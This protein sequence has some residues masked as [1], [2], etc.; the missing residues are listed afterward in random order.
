MFKYTATTAF[1]VGCILLLASIPMVI[2]SAGLGGST[3]S[4]KEAAIGFCTTRTV[5]TP[6]VHRFIANC[7]Y[8]AGKQSV[9]DELHTRCGRLIDSTPVLDDL[10]IFS[11]SDW[12]KMLGTSSIVG[13][14][15]FLVGY[16]IVDRWWRTALAIDVT[17]DDSH[18][19]KMT[20]DQKKMFTRVRNGSSGPSSRLAAANANSDALIHVTPGQYEEAIEVQVN[21]RTSCLLNLD[22]L[23]AVVSAIAVVILGIVLHNIKYEITGLQKY[24][25]F[26]LQNVSNFV[27][28][29]FVGRDEITGGWVQE[30]LTVLSDQVIKYLSV[31]LTALGIS[32]F[33]VAFWLMP[34]LLR[35]IISR[36][37]RA[38]RAQIPTDA[39]QQKQAPA[40]RR[41][42]SP[43][44]SAPGGM[45]DDDQ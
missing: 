26:P 1:V 4:P 34:G 17:I 43:I 2:S 44:A 39:I 33:R 12:L 15:L 37:L 9:I 36:R 25:L 41:H 13:S 14:I 24:V 27:V 23:L 38:N 11:P 16:W 28:G 20:P 5:S 40:Q 10:M 31:A 3:L 45:E 8:E 35:R 32:S 21:E 29:F 42:V 22:L 7:S 30:A 19:N 18:W 6:D